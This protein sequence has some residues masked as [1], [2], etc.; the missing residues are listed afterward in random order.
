[1]KLRVPRIPILSTLAFLLLVTVVVLWVRSPRH[2]DVLAFFTPQGNLTGLASDRRG[3]LFC[4]TQVPF[5]QE[6]GLTADGLTTSAD[7]FASIHDLL[8]DPANEKWHFLGFR[9][10]AGTLSTWGWKFNAI[11]VPYWAL[12]IPLAILP[13]TGLRRL[14]IRARRKRRGQCLNCGYDLRQSPERCPECGRPVDRAGA[15]PDLQAKPS[16]AAVLS[17]LVV[18]GTVLSVG[19]VVARG[20]HAAVAAATTPPELS[21]L[22]RRVGLIDLRGARLN[23]ADRALAKESGARI[24]LDGLDSISP[25]DGPPKRVALRD[26][27]LGTALHTVC[28]PPYSR[29]GDT[30]QIWASGPVVHVG[31][32]SRAPHVIR[33]YPVG[34]LLREVQ[35]DLDRHIEVEA[36]NAASG[37]EGVSN[38]LGPPPVPHRSRTP[39][40]ELATLVTQAIR[41]DDWQENGGDF[42]AV[43]VVAD[44]LW[45]WQTQ[46]GHAAVRTL[47]A[48]LRSPVADTEPATT[49]PENPHANLEQ[50]IPEMSVD[51]PNLEGAIESV[52]QSTHANI[53]VAWTD[54][55]RTGTYLDTPIKLHLWNVT[56]NRVLVAV[57]ALAGGDVPARRT[58][59]D[60]IIYV[61]G[62]ETDQTFSVCVYDVRDV[63]EK[64]HV[65]RSFPTDTTRP[66]AAQ[67]QRAAA[68]ASNPAEAAAFQDLLDDL[69]HLIEDTVDADTWMDNGG[70]TGS[71]RELG[72]R[73]VITQTVATHRKIVALFRTLRAGGSKEGMPLPRLPAEPAR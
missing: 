56:L 42:G 17:W 53:V 44:R 51:S 60:G 29:S 5:G 49:A 73:L 8:F 38:T 7:E 27:S 55:A 13:L 41:V 50:K 33:S 10:A 34:D 61:G 57:F 4:T 70:S 32:T 22:N 23:D 67:A 1:M 12:L 62:P 69:E 43:A 68:D 24:E 9:V 48:A 46:E 26:V 15:S 63:I 65:E 66:A 59:R 3:M 2:A 39:G 52:R 20:R 54:L 18:G 28:Y 11:I 21:T 71:L 40:Q 19:G 16:V 31:T 72:G 36:R 25:T 37:V 64:F 58:G 6:M 47:L 14:V 35:V 30:I 45:V